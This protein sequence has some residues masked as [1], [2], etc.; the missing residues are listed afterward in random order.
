MDS[1]TNLIKVVP[2]NQSYIGIQTNKNIEYELKSHFSFKAPGHKFNKKSGWDG[3]MSLFNM[4]N[5]TIYNGLEPFVFNFAKEKGYDYESEIASEKRK[6]SDTELE[7][8][9]KRLNLP[10]EPYEYQTQAIKFTLGDKRGLVKC[11]TSGGKSLIL[12]IVC[13]WLI[14]ENDESKILIIVPRLN[15]LNQ[16][17][18]NFKEYSE[19]N[20]WPVDDFCSKIKAGEEKIVFRNITIS[21]WQSVYNLD[22]EWFENFDCLLVDEAHHAKAKSLV[23]IATKCFNASYK[24][25]YTGTLD[26]VKINTLT[27]IGL[28]GK[29]ITV[30]NT[31]ELIEKNRVANL[32]IRCVVL[33]YKEKQK[34][35]DYNSEID[36]ITNNENRNR[37]IC[38]LAKSLKGT[39]LILFTRIE[40]G[41][42]IHEILDDKNSFLIYGKIKGDERERIR[43]T[44]NKDER[45]YI[46]TASYET[47]ATGTNIIPIENVIFGS[48]YKS[49]IK[50]LQAIGRG[51]RKYGDKK[52]TIYD[53]ID[54]LDDNYTL[55]HSIHRLKYY[56][57]ENFDYK[58]N[59][60]SI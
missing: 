59:K 51:I 60:I 19:L 29:I 15:L 14:E 2:I 28:F 58:F 9:Y 54:D 55:T 40:H 36:F 25:G 12:Y 6:I 49:K 27:I 7:E 53:L 47:T 42:K 46:L 38:H 8:F 24:V 50:V 45:K 23:D 41:K 22:E 35:K 11:P 20:K 16:L 3:T 34:F 57:Q 33:D 26:D 52:C 37:L 43:Q 48:P 13:R 10:H 44:I 32:D 30:T 21:T 5:K 56:N 18:E 1:R 17:F 39:T 31:K 4:R